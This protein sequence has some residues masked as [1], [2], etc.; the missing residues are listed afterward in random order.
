MKYL[1]NYMSFRDFF[2]IKSCKVK[3]FCDC[4][5]RWKRDSIIWY[6]FV[7][8]LFIFRNKLIDIK[9]LNVKKIFLITNSKFNKSLQNFLHNILKIK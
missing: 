8:Y 9:F 7:S 6:A 1:E 4:S 5:I 3:K 2:W